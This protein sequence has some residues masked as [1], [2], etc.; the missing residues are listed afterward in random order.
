MTVTTLCETLRRAPGKATLASNSPAP[1]RAQH[2]PRGR[3]GK[4]KGSWKASSPRSSGH[5]AHVY[6]SPAK[7]TSKSTQT[8]PQHTCTCTHTHT[9]M[10]AHTHIKGS[11]LFVKLSVTSHSKPSSYH[12]KNY[13]TPL[14]TF[15]H[16]SPLLFSLSH[17]AHDC[18]FTSIKLLLLKI[19]SAI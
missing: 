9:H 17:P 8:A 1:E 4:R 14:P 5:S 19:V 18:I 6:W 10:R 13:F 15:S 2:C 16:V 12:Q 3:E 7:F 11:I